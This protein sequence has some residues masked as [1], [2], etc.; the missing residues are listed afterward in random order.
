MKLL[1]LAAATSIHTQRWIDSINARGIEVLLVTQHISEQWKPAGSVKIYQLPFKGTAG[2]FL[3]VPVLRRII[4]REKPDLMNA[5]YA[6][7][8]GTTASLAGFRPTLL[9]VWG[10]DVF[11]F[12]YQSSYKRTLLRWNLRRSTRLAS[13]SRAMSRQVK[14][15]APET[16]DPYLTPFGV[17]CRRF[18]PAAKSDTHLITIGTVK[19]LA[20]EYGIDI[21]ISAFHALL[22]DP[23]VQES[24]LVDRLRLVL[25]GGGPQE[26]ELKSHVRQLGIEEYVQF[27]GQVSHADVPEWLNRLDLYVAASRMES[28]GVAVLEASACGVPVIVSDA[29]GLPEV[30]ID[31]VTGLV[32]PKDDI[33]SLSAAMLLMIR[34]EP[35]R[36]RMGAAGRD[37]V[38]STYEWEH[39][40]DVMESVYRD[41]IDGKS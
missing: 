3:N 28:F 12:P 1:V 16:P 4:G 8:Y 2:Y 25:V 39:C 5:H 33:A 18:L 41:V 17:D 21:L 22:R 29:G 15:F 20:H 13:T 7:G 31:Q 11:S 14:L 40:V 37:F 30:V 24:A 34:D 36:R 9:S 27:V 35:L 6:S 19:T 38:V 26:S 23:V 10:S 32:V